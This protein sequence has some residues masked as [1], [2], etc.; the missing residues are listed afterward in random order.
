MSLVKNFVTVGGATLSS[1]L[2]GFARDVFMANM[3]GSGPIADAF[4]VAFR[5]PNL[6]RRLFAEGAF[7]AAF[8]PLFGRALAD[9]GKPAARKLAEDILSIFLLSLTVVTIIAELAAP[10]L[11]GILAPGFIKEP[12]KFA[13]AET[14]TRIM[15]PYLA[16]MS[17]TAMAAGMLQSFGRFAVAAFAPSLLNIVLVA[18]L[19]M[20]WWQNWA[21]T[22][23][24]AYTLSWA[25]FI[26]GF[27]QLVAVGGSLVFIG[28]P[29]SL[30]RPGYGDNVKR[31]V[32]L[33]IPGVISGGITQINI[34]VG[35]IIA[36]MQASAVSWLYFA[37][38]IYQLPLGVI[39]VAIGVVL[40]P[41][42]T[43]RVRTDTPENVF[44]TQN[45]ALEFAM[46]LTMPA[47][48]ALIAIAH[49]IMQVLFQRGAFT[50]ADT[51]AT[52]N[53]LIA[54][55][56]GL[57]AFVAIKVFQPSFYAREDTKTPTVQGGISVAVN[58]VASLALFPFIGHVGIAAA[59]SLA[60]WVNALMLVAVLIKRGHFVVDSL[61]VR[62]LVL[63]GV[64]SLAMGG[65]LVLGDRFLADRLASR[66]E[67]EA[68][69]AL[70]ALCL[71]GMLVYGL[72]AMLTGAVDVK[73]YAK[74][75]L[76]R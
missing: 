59:T 2:L 37:D 64:A 10:W 19:A 13:A 16:C 74:A 52:A 34:V 72:A 65:A 51:T 31:F 75:V 49:T 28:F 17:L 39:G 60:A 21:G 41:D 48:V 57:P 40:L 29:V 20:I 69:G 76:K 67:L 66:H 30:T 33:G 3:L 22:P 6:F 46:A 54:F 71:G 12:E 4:F 38:R 50:A 25:V 7:S 24:A 42:L 8:V 53:A 32:N 36:S 45:R 68:G 26:S 62:R 14:M 15:F 73:R 58:V 1:R 5:L 70:L 9:G 47:T 55:S 61:L 44:H 18:A 11:V 56:V 23:Q 27:A 43:R 35:T 63:L